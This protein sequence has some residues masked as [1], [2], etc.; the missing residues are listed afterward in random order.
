MGYFIETVDSIV[1]EAFTKGISLKLYKYEERKDIMTRLLIFGNYEQGIYYL[2]EIGVKYAMNGYSEGIRNRM[3]R[4]R[5]IEEL[6]TQINR[7]TARKQ[8]VTFWM[9]AISFI[10]T[11]ILVIKEVLQ[12]LI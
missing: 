7:Y 3:K 11:T 6:D 1:E 9:A 8:N 10:G 5:E 2:N 4:M 12:C